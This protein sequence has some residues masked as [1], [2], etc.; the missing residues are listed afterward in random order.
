MRVH[1]S[2][3]SILIAVAV[4]AGCGTQLEGRR[5]VRT[6]ADPG[7]FEASEN[8]VRIE[9]VAQKAS[10]PADPDVLV[11]DVDISLQPYLSMV[12]RE[13]GG[14]F[15]VAFKGGEAI[16][17]PTLDDLLAMRL[18]ARERSSILVELRQQITV[19]VSL[20]AGRAQ[21]GGLVEYLDKPR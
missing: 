17:L 10:P 11:K 3:G 7:A 5:G 16:E 1:W 9:S 12:R 8:P 6:T 14:A 19:R 20:H 18:K 4:M 15:L 13:P 2:L 21:K